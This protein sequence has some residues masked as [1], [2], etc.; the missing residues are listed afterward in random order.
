MVSLAELRGPAAAEVARASL[1]REWRRGIDDPGRRRE[2][3]EEALGYVERQ[4]G[5]TRRRR[6]RLASSSASSA[7]SGAG[8]VSA[9]ASSP[10]TRADLLGVP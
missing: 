3:L 8:C 4:L 10:A 5:L 1:R 2:V 7:P 6:E 9:S